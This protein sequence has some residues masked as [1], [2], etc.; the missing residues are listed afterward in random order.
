MEMHTLLTPPQ[1][2]TNIEKH[3]SL[4]NMYGHRLGLWL[5]GLKRYTVLHFDPS[6]VPNSLAGN[7]LLIENLLAPQCKNR[8][9]HHPHQ[10]E[11]SPQR[12]FFKS[13]RPILRDGKDTCTEL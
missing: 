10:T 1:P 9:D 7:F 12:L 11:S 6:P 2:L 4:L 3:P 8:S 13:C 5:L